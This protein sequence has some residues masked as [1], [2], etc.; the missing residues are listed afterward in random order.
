MKRCPECRRDY[1]DETLLYCLDDGTALL[2]GPASMVEPRTAILHSTSPPSEAATRTQ[3]HT[4]AAA[5]ESVISDGRSIGH[6]RASGRAKSLAAVIVAVLIL[7]AGF[8]GY[9]YFTTP[10]STQIDSIAVMPFVNDSGNADV[11][12]LSDGMTE[13]L[14]SNLTQ[15]PNLNVKARSSVFR[16]KGKGIDA[17]TLGKELNVQAILNG[18][19]TQRGDQLVVSLELVDVQT[20]NAIWSQQFIRKQSDIVSLQSEIAREIST[21]LKAKLSGAEETKVT[22]SATADPEAYQAYL[23]GRFYWNQRGQGPGKLAAAIEQFN[24]AVSKDP[25]YALAYAGLADCYALMSQETGVPPSEVLPQAKAFANRALQIDESMSEAHATLG[26]INQSLWQ[27]QDAQKEYER[28]IE[29]NPNYPSA[30]QW[31]SGFLGVMNRPDERLTEIKKAYDLDPLSPAIS[32][33]VG[34][35]HFERGELPAAVEQFKRTVEISPNFFVV[36]VA[37]AT[38]YLKLG[39]VEE[40]LTEAQKAVELSKR[41]AYALSALSRALAAS[42]NKSDALKLIREIEQNPLRGE[43]DKYF[44][45][46]MYAGLGDKDQAFAWL[47]KSFQERNTFLT[48]LRID[49][50][51][52]PLR[53]DPRYK[54]IIRRMGLPE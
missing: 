22:R 9:R 36:H 46:T 38:T 26:L 18:H 19:V 43:S 48:N 31:Y 54:D 41:H 27:W 47:E 14:I 34:L 2:D 24:A 15:L 53:D 21:K 32:V 4:T 13:T 42:G 12:Y 51:M 8:L 11:E 45:S 50:S 44:I 7:V 49:A 25:N 6:E 29:L 39:R 30:H 20:E 37:L 3:I 10:H 16:Y 52:E 35:A 28:S 23:K 1:N 40:A 17:K 5:A 33:N